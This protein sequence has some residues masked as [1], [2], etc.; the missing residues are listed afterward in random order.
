MTYDR[1]LVKMDLRKVADANRGKFAPRPKLVEVVPTAR[2]NAPTGD[3]PSSLPGGLVQTWL[4]CQLVEAGR[5]RLWHIA[6]R[7]ARS[8]ARNGAPARFGSGVNSRCPT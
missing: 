6:E 5:G 2:R 8:S 7:P 4:R 1:E 3:I